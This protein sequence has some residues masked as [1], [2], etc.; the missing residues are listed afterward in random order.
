MTRKRSAHR[1]RRGV[2][3]LV[4]ALALLA[5]PGAASAQSVVVEHDDVIIEH[6]PADAARAA[7]ALSLYRAGREV[8]RSR[9][10]RDVPGRPRVLIAPTDASFQAWVQREAQG[11][12]APSWSAAVAIPSRSVVIL[13][14]P[15]LDARTRP[16]AF[17]ISLTHEIA[18]LA[19]EAVSLARGEP[20]PQ[21]LEEGL[22]SWASDQSMDPDERKMLRARARGGALLPLASLEHRFPENPTD[23]SAAYAQTHALC[24]ELERL[25]GREAIVALLARLE[26][27]YT[28]DGSLQVIAG[29][30]LLDLETELESSLVGERSWW[31]DALLSISVWHIMGLLAVAAVVRYLFK[32][33]RLLREMDAEERA[34]GA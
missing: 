29:I 24:L 7:S 9:L 16:T 25:H 13:R 11:G 2:A 34:G 4:A 3:L 27:G 30:T 5:A 19:L 20:I 22:A 15:A 32:R 28:V 33:R 21:W 23:A 1:A 10:G 14:G 26:R 12:I 8:V 6:I 18:H 17:A 31:L